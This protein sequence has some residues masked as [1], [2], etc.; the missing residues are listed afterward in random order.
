MKVFI[1]GPMSG[2]KDYNKPEFDRMEMQLKDLGYS[3]FNPAWMGFDNTWTREDIMPID[4]AAL[5]KCDAIVML[6]GWEKSAGALAEY[7]YAVATGK[8]LYREG[9]IH[10]LL[11]I[12][13]SAD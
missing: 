6:D 12:E 9:Q 11:W 13:R 4:I 5:G 7:E 1:S 8:I 10:R 3:V 2:I